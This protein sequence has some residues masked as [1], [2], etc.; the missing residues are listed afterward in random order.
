LEDEDS[1]GDDSNPYGYDNA[2]SAIRDD[3]SHNALNVK[4]KKNLNDVGE[5]S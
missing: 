5:M 2:L 1:F 4:T 3:H